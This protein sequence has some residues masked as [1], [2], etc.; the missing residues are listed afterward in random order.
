MK[1]TII[2][3]LALFTVNL[4][5]KKEDIGG[6]GLCACSYISYMGLNLSIKDAAN[7][8]LLNPATSNSFT[9]NQI[10]LYKKAANG[11]KIAISFTIRP[12]FNY[13]NGKFEYFQI[14]SDEIGRITNSI[15]DTY[16]LKLG[17]HEPYVLN[18]GINTTNKKTDRLL[19]DSKEAQ[20]ENNL[21]SEYP[22]NIFYLIRP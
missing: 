12:P 8:D 22:F 4:A 7:Q 1:K 15:H 13:Q 5:C 6:G 16:Y 11:D 17:D 14:F 3:L 9:A 19:I 18:L 10:Q 21:P 20:K 2:I